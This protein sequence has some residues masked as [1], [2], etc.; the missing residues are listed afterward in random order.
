MLNLKPALDAVNAAEATWKNQA[1]QIADLLGEGKETEALALQETLDNAEADYQ[2]KLKL[3][4][5][6]VSANAPS[7]VNQLFV[8]ATST[9]S[10]P[11]AQAPKDVMTLDEFNALAPKDRLAFAKRDGKIQPKED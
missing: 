3:Y 5:K 4:D 6:L 7:N 9:T 11:D 2:N 8:P 1:Q 10:D